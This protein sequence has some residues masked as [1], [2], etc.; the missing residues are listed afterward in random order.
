MRRRQIEKLAA[1]I[2][3]LDRERTDARRLSAVDEETL[4]DTEAAFLA[5]SELRGKRAHRSGWPDFLVVDPE[6]GATIGVEVKAD[7]GDPLRPSQIAMFEALEVVLRIFVWTPR[8][9]ETLTP[10]RRHAARGEDRR[11]QASGPRLT[12]PG[13]LRPAGTSVGA[14][15]DPAREGTGRLK[16]R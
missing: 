13:R 15:S 14:W 3:V 5:R 7:P 9:P 16:N 8:S 10:W 12:A 4:T 11:R 6:S 2:A 1:E